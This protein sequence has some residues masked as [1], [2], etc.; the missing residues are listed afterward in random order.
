MKALPTQ[1]LCLNCHGAPADL[2]PAVKA[3]LAERYPNDK[4]TG[5]AVGQIRGAM[6]LKR[7]L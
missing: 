3:R 5:Y 7:P 2:S 4:A 1:P 6:T